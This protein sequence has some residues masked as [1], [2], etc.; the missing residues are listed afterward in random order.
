VASLV[1]DTTTQPG[2][3]QMTTFRRCS[4][5][6]AYLTIFIAQQSSQPK[7]IAV[8]HISQPVVIFVPIIYII[9]VIIGHN[10]IDCANQKIVA[11]LLLHFADFW[12]GRQVVRMKMVTNLKF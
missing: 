3:Q 8:T 11:N 5:P 7:F 6:N 10:E 4:F 2:E 12:N 1:S 9:I